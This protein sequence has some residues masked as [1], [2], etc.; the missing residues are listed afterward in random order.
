MTDKLYN[1]HVVWPDNC[2]VLLLVDRFVARYY[3]KNAG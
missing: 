2:I 1:F 3:L